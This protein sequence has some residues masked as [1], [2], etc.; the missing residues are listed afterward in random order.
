MLNVL[1]VGA[2][3]LALLFWGSA[4]ASRDE[5]VV[6]LAFAAL[7]ILVFPIFF[8][9]EFVIAPADME[10]EAKVEFAKQEA[11][12]IEGIGKLRSDNEALKRKLSPEVILMSPRYL[13]L[14]FQLDP[15]KGNLSPGDKIEVGLRA[16]DELTRE[17][18]GKNYE[19]YYLA[20]HVGNWLRDNAQ[21]YYAS[22]MN[23]QIIQQDISRKMDLLHEHFQKAIQA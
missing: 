17:V 5:L 7:L 2:A 23:F 8:I 9:R 4:D 18:I 1:L 3:L 22:S 12:Y 13:K 20:V 10:A 14:R 15:E 6:R 11:V 16:L 21:Q 19:S